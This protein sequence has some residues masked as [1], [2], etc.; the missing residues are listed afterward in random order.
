MDLLEIYAAYKAENTDYIEWLETLVNESFENDAPPIIRMRLI[1]T[2]ACFSKLMEQ[3]ATLEVSSEEETNLK[4]L[5]Y[6]L[7][8]SLFLASD[9]VRFYETEDLG[10]FKMRVL[11]YLTKKRRA[12]LFEQH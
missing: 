3:C 1:D 4:D 5:K 10:R 6:L 11:N 7:M 8:D 12:E 2:K 9:L